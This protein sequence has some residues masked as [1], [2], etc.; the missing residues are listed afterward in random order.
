MNAI[1]K[2]AVLAAI[3]GAL[4]MAAPSAA[5]GAESQPQT[6]TNTQIAED[7]LSLLLRPLT[8]DEVGIEVG[9]WR[10]VVK[11]KATEISQAQIAG[12]EQA[13]IS[14][15][16]DERSAL[17][18]RLELAVRAFEAKGGD[19]AEYDKYISEVDQM[20]AGAT[21]VS[22]MWIAVQ[23]W[24]LSEQGGL[25]WAKNI[26]VF[27]VI[28][29]VFKIL[30]SFVAKVLERAMGRMK[31]ASD[32]LRSFFVNTSRKMILFIGLIVAL[33]MIGV[34][35]APFVAAIGA[36]GFVVGFALQGTLSNFASGI[37]ILLYRPYDISD[38][39]TVAGTT[40]KVEAMNLVST[41]L[42]T[43]DNQSLII[44]N[45]SIWGD[46]ITNVTA[47]DVRRVDLVFGIGYADDIAK[48]HK[49]LEDVVAKHELV[50]ADP[51]P[52]IKVHEL[53]DSSVNFVVRPWSKTSD[54]WAVY[55]DLTRTVKERFDAEGISIPFPQQDVYVH[56]VAN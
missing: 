6:T 21:D 27:L 56:Q 43:P 42:L 19:P 1:K 8:M 12:L 40:G 32:L 41:S 50:L 39:V 22:G 49:V 31:T 38:V 15:L 9:G 3:A 33:S 51:E 35:I 10:D 20:A 11:A 54:Y 2:T 37:M 13:A 5:Q 23:H 26:L 55:W 53:A 24:A 14:K 52:V 17:I 47:K 16:A 7:H 48:A 4:V 46:I 28:L 25:M 36:V 29:F 30:A 34:N 45:S 44:P 18:T